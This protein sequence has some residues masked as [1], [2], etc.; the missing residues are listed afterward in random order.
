MAQHALAG[1]NVLA[2]PPQVAGHGRRLVDGNLGVVRVGVLDL[3]HGISAHRQRRAGH[4]LDRRSRRYW[5][6]GR[7][8]GRQGFEDVE[9]GRFLA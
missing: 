5:V 3:H 9:D 4:D 2:A 6:L 7:L 1:V 8:A